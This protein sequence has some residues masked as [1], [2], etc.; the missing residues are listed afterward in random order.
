VS[1]QIEAVDSQIKAT[2]ADVFDKHH[3]ADLP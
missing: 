1:E 3:S 2:L